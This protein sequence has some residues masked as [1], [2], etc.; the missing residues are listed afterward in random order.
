VFYSSRAYRALPKSPIEFVV[1]LQRLMQVKA[2]PKDT[3][4]WLQR[5]GQEPMAP[6]SVKGWDGGPTWI[7][8]STLLARFNYVNRLV[9]TAAPA[10]APMTAMPA[11]LASNANSSASTNSSASA[12]PSA[13]AIAKPA[14]AAVDPATFPA[15]TPDQV[16]QQAGGMDPNRVLEALVA[17]SVQ[18]DVT[19]TVRR[20]L[21]DYL[22]STGASLPV[23]L[24]PENYQEKIRGAL[25]LTLNL[26]SNQLN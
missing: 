8:T 14:T 13:S 22:N 17:D 19:S 18:D 7:N 24:G 1:G 21:V 2:V 3:V 11:M 12:G 9:K 26:P 20:T 23:P 15:W 6:P 25:A 10:P 16:V 5:M 4:Y